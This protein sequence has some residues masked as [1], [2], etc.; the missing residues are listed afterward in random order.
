[1]EML[2]IPKE[3]PRRKK[4]Y[5]G[6]YLHPEDV[7][8]TIS[9]VQ[10]QDMSATKKLRENLKCQ[11]QILETR[12]R[13]HRKTTSFNLYSK[14]VEGIIEAHVIEKLSEIKEIK[15]KYQNKLQ[16]LGQVT[17][18][19]KSRIDESMADELDK[20]VKDLNLSLIHI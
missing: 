19:T 12:K 20:M 14:Q 4:T 9:Y 5:S 11:E 2:I 8:N 17:S 13:R 6:T 15:Q 10:S 3:K 7:E 16:E 18:R 1:M